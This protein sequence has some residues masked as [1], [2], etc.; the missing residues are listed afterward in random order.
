MKK[1]LSWIGYLIG[2][3]IPSV[4]IIVYRKV[5]SIMSQV[6]I[7][8]HGSVTI[9]THYTSIGI[10]VLASICAALWM[11]YFGIRICVPREVKQNG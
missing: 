11:I 7:W 10:G 5:Y 4:C 3:A 9:A 8:V 2:F 1:D 6:P